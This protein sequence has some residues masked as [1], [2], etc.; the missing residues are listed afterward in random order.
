LGAHCSGADIFC[1]EGPKIRN[2]AM[3]PQRELY[4]FERLRREISTPTISVVDFGQRMLDD[5]SKFVA[6]FPQSDDMC[7]VWV[8]EKA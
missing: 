6:G 3:N 8:E 5:V 4:G 2:E 1:K 7:L